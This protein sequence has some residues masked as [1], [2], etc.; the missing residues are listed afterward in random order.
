MCFRLTALLTW[1]KW[2][3]LDCSDEYHYGTYVFQAHSTA[4]LGQVEAFR[5]L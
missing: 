2:R 1:D 5:L 3:L 4:D